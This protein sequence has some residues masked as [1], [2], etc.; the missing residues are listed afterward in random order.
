M[1][2]HVRRDLG[3]TLVGQ[4]PSARCLT[5][6]YGEE[7]CCVRAILR[8]PRAGLRRSAARA[9]GAGWC[10]WQYCNAL[11]MGRRGACGIRRGLRDRFDPDITPAVLTMRQ[12]P[13][14]STFSPL[15]VKVGVP[16]AGPDLARRF[17]WIVGRI[18]R[19]MIGPCRGIRLVSLYTV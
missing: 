17:Q 5:S 16:R 14:G 13:R 9:R 11:A 8:H 15:G 10:K 18:R 12:P 1:P 4:V 19:G 6:Q 3:D 7:A 2:S